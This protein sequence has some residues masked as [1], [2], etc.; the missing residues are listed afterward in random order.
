VDKRKGRFEL[1]DHGTI[2]LD[3]VG[4]IP[5][6]MQAKLLR[7]LQERRFERVGGAVSLEVDVR[8]VGATNRNLR[9]L[10]KQGKFREDLFY[11]LNVVKIDLPPLRERPEDIPLLATHFTERYARH[12]T[13]PKIISP[14]A[15]ELLL[16][17]SW[18]GNIRE[19]ENAVE[20]ACVTARGPTI[21]S[22]DLPP[23]VAAPRPMQT[24]ST[25]DVTRPLPDQLRQVV[26]DVEKQYLRKALKKARGNVGRCARISGLSRRSVSAK[27]AEYGIDKD[28][29]KTDA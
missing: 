24:V 20:R 22:T 25:V 28:E 19:L 23:D 29:F 2:F 3:E 27:L 13:A 11:R 26:A 14:D 12:G 10:V 6:P 4:D 8:V 21:L 9:R 16:A 17:Y 15:M 1:A 18:P 7:V 5:A